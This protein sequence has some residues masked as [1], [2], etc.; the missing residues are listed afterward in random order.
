[1]SAIPEFLVKPAGRDTHRADVE[2]CGCGEGAKQF[3]DPRSPVVAGMDRVEQV[4]HHRQRTVD[5]ELLGSVATAQVAEEGY[6]VGGRPPRGGDELS[7]EEPSVVGMTMN[8]QPA[9][10]KAC[11]K[12]GCGKVAHST[13]SPLYA[14]GGVTARR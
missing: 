9:S 11:Q 3:G 7:V 14:K 5:P 4:R 2:M 1:M 12:R 6:L 10:V 13:Q 8:Y